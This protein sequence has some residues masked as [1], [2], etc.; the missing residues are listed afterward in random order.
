MEPTRNSQLKLMTFNCDLDIKS[1]WLSYSSQRQT[2]D[3]NL[4]KIFQRVQETWSGCESVT[5][6][7]ME[8]MKAIPI[9]SFPFI[10][11]D[12]NLLL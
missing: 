12:S 4:L 5:D 9:I 8:W 1:A 7:Q 11:G 3:K 2:F 10:A 6:R